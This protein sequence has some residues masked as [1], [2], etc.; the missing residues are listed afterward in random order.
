[1]QNAPCQLSVH[2]AGERP[3]G[4]AHQKEPHRVLAEAGVCRALLCLSELQA[5]HQPEGQT[6]GLG[7]LPPHPLTP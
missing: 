1:M 3:R 4:E 2:L 7:I 5:K 6:N